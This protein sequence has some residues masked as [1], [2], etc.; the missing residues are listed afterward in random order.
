MNII[1]FVVEFVEDLQ[2]TTSAQMHEELLQII[3][4]AV[5]FKVTDEDI[6]Y[7]IAYVEVMNT[8]EVAMEI[9]VMEIR[10]D[11]IELLRLTFYIFEFQIAEK[12][13]MGNILH[14]TL[15]L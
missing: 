8:V 5:L 6:Q 13:K 1:F 10:K 12:E 14:P 15:Y 3:D 7:D 2:Q 9:P 11:I 4:K